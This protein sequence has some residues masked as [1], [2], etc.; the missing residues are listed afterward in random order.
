MKT[1]GLLLLCLLLKMELSITSARACLPDVILPSALEGGLSEGQACY[2]GE[3]WD[4]QEEQRSL[5]CCLL[6]ACRK[7]EER[8]E[9]AFF[10]AIIVP[11]ILHY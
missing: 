10:Y 11:Y 3:G 9:E 1:G 2:A 4:R 5:C 8:Q 7:E 6:P